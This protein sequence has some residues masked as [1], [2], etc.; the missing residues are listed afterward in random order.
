MLTIKS[1]YV[2][3]KQYSW[4]F[5]N[6]VLLYSYNLYSVW[7]NLFISN[8]FIKYKLKYINIKYNYSN[9]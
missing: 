6:N 1:K 8:F 2:E 5:L 9:S 4:I 3:N 7:L